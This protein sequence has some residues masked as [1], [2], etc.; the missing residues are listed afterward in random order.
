M[1]SQC[2]YQGRRTSGDAGV[3]VW[4][5]KVL[6]WGASIRPP[7]GASDARTLDGCITC[8]GT[9]RCDAHRHMAD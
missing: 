1:K 5:I 7:N 4:C 9:G 2:N 6:T 8:N 3:M